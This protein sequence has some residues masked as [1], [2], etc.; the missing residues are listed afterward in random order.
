MTPGGIRKF[1]DTL[2]GFTAAEQPGPIHPG[3]RAGHDHL[4][5]LGLLRDRAGRVHRADALGPAADHAARLRAGQWR[6][7]SRSTTWAR[8]SSPR[9]TGRCASSSATCCPTGG[10]GNLFIPVDTTVMGSGLTAHGHEWK[11]ATPS[12]TRRTRCAADLIRLEQWQWPLLHREP[13]HPAPARRHHAL[14]QRR[15][16]APV[17]HAGGREHRRIPQGVSVRPVPDMADTGSP[18]TAT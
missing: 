2:P 12:W 15:H 6:A 17:D 4:S 7:Q 5:R 3:G 11:D 1:V 14:D 9:R 8:R 18:T 16:A 13:G 10:G